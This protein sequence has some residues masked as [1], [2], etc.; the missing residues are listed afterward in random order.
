MGAG[1]ERTLP[2]PHCPRPS[3]GT[4]LP[5]PQA[6]GLRD[7]PRDHLAASLALPLSSGGDEKRRTKENPQKATGGGVVVRGPGGHTPVGAF[8][9]LKRTFKKKKER[10]REE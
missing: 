6:Q 8:I 9:F 1:L 10:G 2:A 4:A 3:A 7:P 5:V